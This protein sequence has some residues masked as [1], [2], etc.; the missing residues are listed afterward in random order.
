MSFQGRSLVEE[1][2]KCGKIVTKLVKMDWIILQIW[3]Y[4]SILCT[5]SETSLAIRLFTNWLTKIQASQDV[6]IIMLQATMVA[7]GLGCAYV[8]RLIQ[9]LPS[10]IYKSTQHNKKMVV[11]LGLCFIWTN[12]HKIVSP[13]QCHRGSLEIMRELSLFWAQWTFTS[14]IVAIARNDIAFMY[15]T[16][17]EPHKMDA[18]PN[19]NLDQ[20]I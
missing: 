5:T 1:C 19:F 17:L 9:W 7:Q 18:L 20:V 14:L 12:K 10:K 16:T 8:K 13:L 4:F 6:L 15:R 11:E 2:T 3:W